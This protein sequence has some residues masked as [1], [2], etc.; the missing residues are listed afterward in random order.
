MQVEGV[1]N[2]SENER[3]EEPRKKQKKLS[4]VDELIRQV[5]ASYDPRKSKDSEQQVLYDL[6]DYT[7][8][9]LY[10]SYS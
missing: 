9:C 6:Y 4:T 3:K 10:N 1:D 7:L 5:I 2:K 8:Y